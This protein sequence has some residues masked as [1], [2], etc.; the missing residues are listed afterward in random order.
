[1]KTWVLEHTMSIRLWNLAISMTF[2]ELDST[3]GLYE[4]SLKRA[5]ETIYASKVS[6]AS[7]MVATM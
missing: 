7:F 6:F 4:E 3:I 2:R 5:F 1:M